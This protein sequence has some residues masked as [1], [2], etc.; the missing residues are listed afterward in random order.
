MGVKNSLRLNSNGCKK[1]L[2]VKWV[3][4]FL[5]SHGCKK[6]FGVKWVYKYFRCQTSVKIFLGVKLVYKYFTSQLGVKKIWVSNRCKNVSGVQW[7]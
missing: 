5:A 7:L 4:I 3:K 2:G 1:I 6:L